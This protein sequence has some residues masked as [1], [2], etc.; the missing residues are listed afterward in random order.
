MINTHNWRLYLVPLIADVIHDF[1]VLTS[2]NPSGN[3]IARLCALF[4]ILLTITATKIATMTTQ[5]PQDTA[6]GSMWFTLTTA[7]PASV[8]PSSA[9]SGIAANHTRSHLN[10]STLKPYNFVSV[11]GSTFDCDQLHVVEFHWWKSSENP[12][13]QVRR[14]DP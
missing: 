12:R 2:L 4:R 9:L 11:K 8:P 7:P 3:Q 13:K 14:T 5:T 6:T 1:L 10:R